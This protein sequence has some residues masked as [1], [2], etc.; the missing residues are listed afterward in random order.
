[1]YSSPCFLGV[2]EVWNTTF[3]GAQNGGIF[4]TPAFGSATTRRLDRRLRMAML[5]S[6][7]KRWGWPVTCES[8]GSLFL[9]NQLQICQGNDSPWNKQVPENQWL[10]DETTFL[11]WPIFSLQWW[12]VTF[13][14]CLLHL[15]VASYASVTGRG[16]HP[17]HYFLGILAHL[18]MVS[19]S[20]NRGG[21][22]GHPKS[23]WKQYDGWCNEGLATDMVESTM[24]MF[25]QSK[26]VKY[27]KNVFN[28]SSFA[29]EN[30]SQ[31]RI[32]GTLKKKLRTGKTPTIFNWA[33]SRYFSGL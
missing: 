16:P 3:K 29:P 12:V 27:L 14:E 22:E 17:N 20:L 10:E 11:V 32:H 25:L 9:V 5:R 30:S 2:V 19:W 13:M 4:S 28:L 21:D 24:W 1:M 23:S 6:A 15:L 8:Q 18:R 26:H 7:W 33:S 31:E